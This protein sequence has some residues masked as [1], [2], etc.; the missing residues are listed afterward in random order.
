MEQQVLNKESSSNMWLRLNK[1]YF[2]LLL[3]PFKCVCAFVYS[4]IMWYNRWLAICAIRVIFR[5]DVDI[6][7][8][9]FLCVSNI[10]K[11]SR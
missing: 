1:K 6:L 5:K 2:F 8:V 7:Q 10:T 9:Y 3:R 4:Y 11:P